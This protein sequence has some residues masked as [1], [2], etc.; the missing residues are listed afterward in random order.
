MSALS[1]ISA[2]SVQVQPEGQAPSAVDSKVK[3]GMILQK[4]ESKFVGGVPWYPG[5]QVSSDDA[6]LRTPPVQ[7]PSPLLQSVPLLTVPAGSSQTFPEKR[8]TRDNHVGNKTRAPRCAISKWERGGGKC[9]WGGRWGEGH[10]RKRKRGVVS[11]ENA[12]DTQ[13]H[14]TV[15]FILARSCAG[16]KKSVQA[17]ITIRCVGVWR[18]REDEDARRRS[19]E[20]NS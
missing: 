7:P 4:T 11:A 10:K 6:A 1:C 9:V 12:R 19:S 14:G 18:T 3:R 5:A 20:P 15:C 16:E 2:S 13:K 8:A 17:N